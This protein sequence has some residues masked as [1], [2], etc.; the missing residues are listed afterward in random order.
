M[1]DAQQRERGDDSSNEDLE[2]VGSV[3]VSDNLYDYQGLRG[4]LPSYQSSLSRSFHSSSYGSS[5]PS[6]SRS[7]PV[8]S[9]S[10]GGYEVR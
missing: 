9:S 6:Y 5:V 3:S 4:S 2:S 7:P 1:S 10:K 8:Y